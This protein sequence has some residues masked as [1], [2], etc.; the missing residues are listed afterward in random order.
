MKYNYLYMN[1]RLI[2]L[3]LGAAVCVCGLLFSLNHPFEFHYVT[4]EIIKDAEKKHMQE[5]IDDMKKC[6]EIEKRAIKPDAYIEIDHSHKYNHGT[7]E[8]YEQGLGTV[9]Q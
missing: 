2:A 1:L 3:I 5:L 8:R 9:G 6:M 4:E 7:Y